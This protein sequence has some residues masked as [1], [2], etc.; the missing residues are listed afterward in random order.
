MKC[1]FPIAMKLA[2]S[3]AAK[4]IPGWTDKKPS[5]KEVKEINKTGC[6]KD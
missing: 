6:E 3:D 4:D 5:N 2:N 1:Y